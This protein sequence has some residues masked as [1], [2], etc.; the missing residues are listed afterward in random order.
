[1]GFVSAED[2]PRHE[3]EWNDREDPAWRQYLKEHHRKYHEWARSKRKEQD[4]YWRWR[5]QHR[6][7]H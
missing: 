5:D 1:M 3:H 6:D 2:H 4:E 7:G